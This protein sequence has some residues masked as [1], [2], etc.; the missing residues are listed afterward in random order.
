MG[1]RA[2]ERER[3][4]GKGE[5][6]SD[7]TTHTYRHGNGPHMHT[8]TDPN[9]LQHTC[10]HRGEITASPATYM[11]GREEGEGGGARDP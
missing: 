4:G 1:G 10:T 7:T 6:T 2:R 11:Q 3:E 5:R 8:N 9:T